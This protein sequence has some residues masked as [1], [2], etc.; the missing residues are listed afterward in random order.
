MASDGLPHQVRRAFRLLDEDCNGFLSADEFK[1]ILAM[2][3][4]QS[5]PDPVF[6]RII[7]LIDKNGTNV[8]L[9]TSACAPLPRHL[10]A[11]KW[12]WQRALVMNS[13]AA[14]GARRPLW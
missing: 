10:C 12:H 11:V 9:V 5:M 3:N 8:A 4:M 2:F 1:R 14:R 7:Q 6:N 13:R